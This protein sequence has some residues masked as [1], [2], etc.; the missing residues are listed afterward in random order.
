MEYYD[1]ENTEQ[2][3]KIVAN[4]REKKRNVT[5]AATFYDRISLRHR[6]DWSRHWL[7][8]AVYAVHGPL[9]AVIVVES[10]QISRIYHARE[11][12]RAS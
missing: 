12:E 8:P 7:A 9:R 2:C 1:S 5:L 3:A 11:S 4:S 10:A 6:L